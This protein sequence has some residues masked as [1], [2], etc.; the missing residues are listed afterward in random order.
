MPHAPTTVWPEESLGRP[1]T[2][3]VLAW[4]GKRTHG[5]Q[6]LLFGLDFIVG[7]LEHLSED[8]GVLGLGLHLFA[9]VV[10]F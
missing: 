5:W 8:E 1:G 2:V 4:I 10:F 7:L 9:L 3:Q 6:W